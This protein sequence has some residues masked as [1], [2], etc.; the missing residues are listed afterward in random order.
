MLLACKKLPEFTPDLGN[1][2][3]I[4]YQLILAN[5]LLI[6]LVVLFYFLGYPVIVIAACGIFFFAL[7]NFIFVARMNK[8]KNQKNII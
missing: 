6:C 3:K 5:L 8:S 1:N 7:A 4:Q 2:M